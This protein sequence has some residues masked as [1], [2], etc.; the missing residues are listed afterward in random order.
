MKLK[1]M[2]ASLG[3]KNDLKN[4]NYIFEPK[5]D[6]YRALCLFDGK[7]LK[8]VS[9]YDID[10]TENYPELNF[11]KNLKAKNC[12][13]DGE[14]VAYNKKGLPDFS[15]LQEGGTGT[16]VVFDILEKNNK[17][18][19]NKPILERKKIL[20]DTVK[21]GNG[22]ETIVFT[23]DGIDL[24][25]KIVKL[26][27]EG[28]MAKEINSKYYPGTRSKVW[29]KIKQLKTADC[30]IIGYTQKQRLVSSLAL[31]LYDQYGKLHY[32]GKVGTGFSYDFIKELKNILDKIHTNK[33]PVKLETDLHNVT[34]VKPKLVCEVKFVELTKAKKLRSPVFLRLR[35]D[36]KTKACLFKQQF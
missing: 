26:G 10:I 29:I 8:F 31:G 14:I 9:R 15:L 3:N 11:A 4:K 25:K 2:N 23:Y 17:S 24:W 36:K 6:G 7:K 12:V 28:I 16:F 13:L 30:V 32:I 34:F 19:V 27:L 20:Q 22:I 1:V 18:L 35:N 5:L 33:I 21:D